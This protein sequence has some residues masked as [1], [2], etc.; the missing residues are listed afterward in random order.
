V[1]WFTIERDPKRRWH[2]L[3]ARIEIEDAAVAPVSE[4]R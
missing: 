1:G 2:Y 3:G 4:P